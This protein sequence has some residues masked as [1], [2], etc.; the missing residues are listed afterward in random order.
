VVAFYV[1][2]FADVHATNH[3]SETQKHSEF[4][5]QS[6]PVLALASATLSKVRI[7]VSKFSPSRADMLQVGLLPAINMHHLGQKAYRLDFST[8]FLLIPARAVFCQMK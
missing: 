7:L 4:W 5:T 1:D 2:T 8:A 6:Q 3:N